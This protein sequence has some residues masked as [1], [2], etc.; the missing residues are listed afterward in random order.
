[1]NKR[2]IQAH[3][4]ALLLALLSFALLHRASQDTG[5]VRDEAA[6]FEAS[7]RMR[8][9]LIKLSK[10]P[11]SAIKR[12]DRGFS[13]NHEH[14]AGTKLL[15]ALTI[16]DQGKS[17]DRIPGQRLRS[18]A[19]VIAA[20]GVY[21]LALIGI[22]RYGLGI[23]LFCGAAFLALPRV[24]Y[25]AQLHC[26][27]VSIAVLTLATTAAF[28]RFVK[29][30][31][32]R[33]TLL[34]GIAFGL[35]LSVKHNALLLPVFLCVP[36]LWTHL[37]GKAWRPIHKRLLIRGALALLLGAGI[38]VLAWPW[39]WSDPLSRWLEYI[40]FHREHSYYNMA[41]LGHNYNQPPLPWAYP[42]V[43]TAVTWPLSWLALALGGMSLGL[44]RPGLA[45]EKL[46]AR[47][48]LI[49]ALAPLVLISLPSVPIF[50][51]TKHWM[52]AY[53][54]LCLL[55]GRALF[56]LTERVGLGKTKSGK[57]LL[58][59]GLL[60]LLSPALLDNW[61]S[62][63]KQLAQY[64]SWMGGP[65]AGARL[66]LGRVFWGGVCVPE[67]LGKLG[68][69]DRVFPHDMHPALLGAYRDDARVDQTKVSS[70]ARADWAFSFHEDHQRIDQ[71]WTERAGF[72]PS[73]RWVCTLDDVPLMSLYKKEDGT[74]R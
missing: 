41:F 34:L 66:G 23:G 52:T 15:A 69:N 6:Y 22:R 30:P 12:K 47:T 51:G 64:A 74:S 61:R 1:M 45:Q 65:R 58:G 14:P 62:H 53:P 73:P 38:F 31:S 5:Y 29:A 8:S 26:F 40:E 24:F 16:E 27:D 17:R 68:K 71:V 37:E 35:A 13:Y 11:V 57:M 72:G 4:C 44:L 49:M 70:R 10:D 42:W 60:V 33:N 7:L 20:L 54:F 25:H 55:M 21:L 28:L 43:L 48:D 19:Q 50:G 46:Q 3:L 9:W 39:L 2:G 32:F 59:T 67:A 63:P 18:V 36:L 56:Q